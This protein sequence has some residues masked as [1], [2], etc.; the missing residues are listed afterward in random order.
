[1]Y[2]TLG[3][4]LLAPDGE[5]EKSLGLRYKSLSNYERRL[6]LLTK[7]EDSNYLDLVAKDLLNTNLFWDL[8]KDGNYDGIMKIYN[9]FYNKE[10]N[11]ISKITSISKLKDSYKDYGSI[12]DNSK[13]LKL[14]IKN[15]SL[16]IIKKSGSVKYPPTNTTYENFNNFI[17]WYNINTTSQINSE[18]Y[19]SPYQLSELLKYNILMRNNI[20]D[21][22]PKSTESYIYYNKYGSDSFKELWYTIGTL[23]PINESTLKFMA[24]LFNEKVFVSLYKGLSNKTNNL[25]KNTNFN[26]NNNSNVNSN[27]LMNDIVGT[28]LETDHVAFFIIERFINYC[29]IL[30]IIV[31]DNLLRIIVNNIRYKY[32]HNDSR[33]MNGYFDLIDEIAKTRPID[34]VYNDLTDLIMSND[35]QEFNGIIDDYL[36]NQ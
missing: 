35:N 14:L 11:R 3:D 19:Y 28:L 29:K 31:P 10:A 2:Y 25:N 33:A 13:V 4:I 7:M 26:T 21:F 32:E 27:R 20:N 22:M 24:N 36:N 15:V 17:E 5:V 1:M 18:N 6:V 34:L 8:F 9:H 30:N 12:L 23:L 16:I